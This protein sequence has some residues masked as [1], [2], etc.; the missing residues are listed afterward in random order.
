[1][2]LFSSKKSVELPP[3]PMFYQDPGVAEAI[4]N[5]LSIG[6]AYTTGYGLTPYMQ[7]AVST[8]PEATRNAI[9]AASSML[10]PELRDS[11]KRIIADLEANNQLTGST[12]ASTLADLESDYL[13]QITSAGLGMAAS[14]IERALGARLTLAGLGVNST[15]NA[16]SLALTNQGQQNEFNLANYENQVAKVLAGQ[17][18][19]K[20]GL[21]G[22]LTGGAGGLMA[23]LALAP[24][25][26]G[27]SLA[28]TGGLTGLGALAGGLGPS[29]TGGAIMQSGAGLAGA[30]LSQPK[31]VVQTNPFTLSNVNSGEVINDNL[32][33][34]GGLGRRGGF[35]ENY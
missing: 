20:G 7:E 31:P 33:L 34:V 8:S 16:G 26:G 19:S 18:D 22:A 27:A 9:N 5:G 15:S 3:P 6:S 1:M 2:G 23:G 28:V 25:T 14:D 12:T 21:L 4:R 30:R 29:G 13:S 17:K 35:W 24:F 11:R 10:L 32:R